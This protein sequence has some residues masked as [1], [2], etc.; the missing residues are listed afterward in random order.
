[1]L[2]YASRHVR[3]RTLAQIYSKQMR[4]D[5]WERYDSAES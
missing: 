3:W 5:R 2:C 1:M 4:S